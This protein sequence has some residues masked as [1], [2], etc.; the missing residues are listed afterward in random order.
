MRLEVLGSSGTA[1]RAGNPASSYLVRSDSSTVWMDAGPGSYM[2]LLDK[3]D[4]ERIDGVLLSHLHPDH[5]SDVF[6]LFHELAYVR[7]SAQSIPVVVPDGSMARFAGFL[8]GE[9]GHAIFQTF[10]FRE[11]QPDDSILIGDITVT[12]AAAHHSVPALAFR[13]ES[14]GGAIGYTGDTGP[15]E[16]VAEH[17]SGVDLLLAEASLQDHSDEYAFHMTARQAATMAIQGEVRHL[18]LTHIPASLDPTVSRREAESVFAGRLSLAAPG[19]TY[20][21]GE[22]IDQEL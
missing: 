20:M 16:M 5:C 8:G 6:A 7:R 10:R 14:G 12:V 4:P 22:P 13:V 2:A 11:A 1:P 18:V 19:E 3:V 15:S 21:I 17:L 9:P